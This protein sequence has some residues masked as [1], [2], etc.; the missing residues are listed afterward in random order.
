MDVQGL[1]QKSQNRVDLLKWQV[2][3]A[4]KEFYVSALQDAFR[5]K[6]L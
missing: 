6:A 5:W 2:K 3:I 4:A 1:L